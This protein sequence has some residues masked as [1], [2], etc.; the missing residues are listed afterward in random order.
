MW[1]DRSAAVNVPHGIMSALTRNQCLLE[2][3]GLFKTQIARYIVVEYR[4]EGVDNDIKWNI[5]ND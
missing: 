5:A 4:N 1:A 3:I 2:D